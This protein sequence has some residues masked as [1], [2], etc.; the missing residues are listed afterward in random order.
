MLI[1]TWGDVFSSSLQGLWSGVI[2]FIPNLIIAILIFIIGWV[3]GSVV[4]KALIQVIGVLKLDKLFA[5]AGAET[6]MNKA[7][8]KLSVGGFLGGL[9]KW[10]IITLFLIT[11]L[12]V[13]KL[14]QVNQF[15]R[16]VVLNYLPQVIVAA[17]VLII[18]T[19]LSDATRKLVA[20]SAKAAE[21][22]LEYS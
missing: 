6:L 5:S 2:G 19:V 3:V 17:L 22:L 12:D 7:G 18:A 16:E 11:S 10:F 15:L 14:T 8:M 13:L 1:Q 9:V 20:G 21:M 4:E